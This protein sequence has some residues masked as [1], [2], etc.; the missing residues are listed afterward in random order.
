[1]N[2]VEVDLW[3]GWPAFQGRLPA[4]SDHSGTKATIRTKRSTG[5][6]K[7]Q[8]WAKKQHHGHIA[9]KQKGEKECKGVYIAVLNPDRAL[10]SPLSY[11][12]A[13]TCL[14]VCLVSISPLPGVSF[15]LP[16]RLIRVS[17]KALPLPIKLVAW[18]QREMEVT[19]PVWSLS[20]DCKMISLYIAERVLTA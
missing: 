16:I 1:M 4:Y 3:L 15:L 5:L 20:K 17:R 19:L 6:L 10:P 11:S 8:N 2:V 13:F 12:T 14:F 9:G 18:L 7:E